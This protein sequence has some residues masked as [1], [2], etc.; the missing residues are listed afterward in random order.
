MGYSLVI[1]AAIV[2]L[3]GCTSFH[4][5]RANEPVPLHAKVA[6]TFDE[7]RDLEARRETTVYS[8]PEVST[9]YGEVEEVRS[10]T[11]MLRLIDLESGRR[12][13][14][15]PDE[16]RLALVPG[17]SAQVSTLRVSKWRTAGMVSLSAVGLFFY[18]VSQMEW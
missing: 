9:V 13:P 12:Q 17:P 14:R 3:S 16:A 11:L 18:F 1:A 5:V 10:D 2:T 15:L 8:L 6:I 7:P 4:L